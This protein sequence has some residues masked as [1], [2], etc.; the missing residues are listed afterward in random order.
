MMGCVG[1]QQAVGMITVMALKEEV[2][3]RAYL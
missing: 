1:S 3:G 2:G